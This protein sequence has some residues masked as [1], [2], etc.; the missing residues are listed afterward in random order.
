MWKGLREVLRVIDR[1]D[2]DDREEEEE[3]GCGSTVELLSVGIERGWIGEGDVE[4]FKRALNAS[5]E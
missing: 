4:G 3:A 2:V 5:E 1:Y